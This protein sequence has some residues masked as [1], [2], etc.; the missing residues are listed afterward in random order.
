MSELG[1]NSR[2]GL[3]SDTEALD[4]PQSLRTAMKASNVCLSLNDM[5]GIMLTNSVTNDRP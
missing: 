3:R 1:G 4:D 2:H 5:S